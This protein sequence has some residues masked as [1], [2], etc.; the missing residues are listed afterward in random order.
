MKKLIVLALAVVIAAC[1][2]V[3]AFAD[4]ATPFDDSSLNILLVENFDNADGITGAYLGIPDG[5]I[6]IDNPTFS[7]AFDFE[8]GAFNVKEA[9]ANTAWAGIL[10]TNFA[11]ANADAEGVGFYIKNN[12][13]E[14]VWNFNLV[15]DS[16]ASLNGLAFAIGSDKEYALVDMEGNK[17]VITAPHTEHPN[18]P[19][20]V[21]HSNLTLPAGFEGFVLIPLANMQQSWSSNMLDNSTASFTGFGWQN[22]AINVSIDNIFFYGANVNGNCEAAD[23][24]GEGATDSAD[25][26][27]IAYAAAAIVGLGALVV[28]K[29]R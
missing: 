17:T 9:A 12:G 23:L 6:A 4:V 18:A 2:G 21:V 13:D 11:G 28:A 27:V 1:V 7:D 14:V 20:T 26:S 24:L 5:A 3:T 25:V 19:G 10:D 8:N 22:S 29:K 15:C 16:N